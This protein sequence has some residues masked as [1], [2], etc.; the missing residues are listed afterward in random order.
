MG[1]MNL[2]ALFVPAA[3]LAACAAGLS[4]QVIQFES[5]G[6]KYQTLSKKGITV[7]FAYL[8]AH[9][10]D[11]QIIQVS[12]SNGSEGS[13]TVRPEDFIFERADGTR[14]YA[15]AAKVVVDR[16]LDHATRNDVVKLI[17]TYENTLN[18]VPRL[19]STNGYEARRE[20]ALAEIGSSKVKA[21]AAASAIA[22]V[23]TRIE[24]GESTDGAV[25]FA[26]QSKLAG[27]GRLLVRMAGQIFEFEPAPSGPAKTLQ[28]R[29]PVE[30]SPP[31]P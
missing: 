23:Q 1:L 27:A 21:A 24:P 13:C 7:M 14:I 15:T 28:Q 10:H 30:S 20:S 29:G 4:A 22:L 6:L 26:T 12:V 3:V 8:P 5:A 9:L 19:R 16:L 25:F 31:K 2:R 11:Y 17:S 18:G